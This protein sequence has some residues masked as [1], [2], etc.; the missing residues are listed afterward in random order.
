MT[1]HQ[2][3]KPTPLSIDIDQWRRDIKTF[4]ET[5]SGALVA[6]I[7]Q[8]SNRCATTHSSDPSPRRQAALVTTSTSIS[9][10]MSPTKEDNSERLTELKSRL[11]QQISQSNG[12]PCS[13][14]SMP[15]S[16]STTQESM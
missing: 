2:T 3:A 13:E 14:N 8:L 10:P 7:E 1:Q 6:I 12:T 5:T 11:A 9:R 15:Q 16:R 4:S